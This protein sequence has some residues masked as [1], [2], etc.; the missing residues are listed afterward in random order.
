MYFIVCLPCVFSEM[1]CTVPGMFGLE[2]SDFFCVD[3]GIP[4][5]IGILF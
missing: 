2:D 3:T 1:K 5:D 4:V